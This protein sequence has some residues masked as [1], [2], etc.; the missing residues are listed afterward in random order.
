[1]I[2]SED[3]GALRS[4]GPNVSDEARDAPNS[5]TLVLVGSPRPRPEPHS[6]NVREGCSQLQVIAPRRSPL[7][8]LACIFSVS[9]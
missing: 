1:M 3:R 6:L 2:W 5:G 7:G 8:G 4:L 9:S